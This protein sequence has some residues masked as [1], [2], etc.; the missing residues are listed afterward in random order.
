MYFPLATGPFAF[1][2]SHY[3]LTI[4]L[5]GMVVVTSKTPPLFRGVFEIGECELA[6]VLFTFRLAFA[7]HKSP[8]LAR[9]ACC[10]SRMRFLLASSCSHHIRTVATS[11]GRRPEVLEMQ[12]CPLFW[13]L[14]A[15]IRHFCVS[16]LGE[17]LRSFWRSTGMICEGFCNGPGTFLRRAVLKTM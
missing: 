14:E 9:P 10:P 3:S 8:L 2:T 6:T 12:H 11:G 7:V 13:R 17:V 16:G 5:L 4:R 1:W 15:A